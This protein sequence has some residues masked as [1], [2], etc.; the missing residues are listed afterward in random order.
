MRLGKI[1]KGIGEQMA[2]LLGL[3][4]RAPELVCNLF[5]NSA[6]GNHEI[7]FYDEDKPRIILPGDGKLGYKLEVF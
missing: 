1:S 7:Y 2:E 6:S 5:A 3:K 4:R